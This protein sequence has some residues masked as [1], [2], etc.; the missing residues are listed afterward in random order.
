MN[1]PRIKR[2]TARVA[3][4]EG[5]IYLLREAAGGDIHIEQPGKEGRR[6]LA[7]LDGRLT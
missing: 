2:T 5:D 4:P 1:R 3:T 6:L 7:A